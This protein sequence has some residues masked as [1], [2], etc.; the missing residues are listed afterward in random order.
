[1]PLLP[2]DRPVGAADAV[3][4]TG[5]FGEVPPAGGAKLRTSQS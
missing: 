2:L 3:L 1:M 4:D 5:P